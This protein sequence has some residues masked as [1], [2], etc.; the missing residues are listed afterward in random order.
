MKVP[1]WEKAREKIRRDMTM[2]CLRLDFWN[3]KKRMT[4]RKV[5][6]KTLVV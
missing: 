5:L 4:M 3:V 1:V 2:K 6:T